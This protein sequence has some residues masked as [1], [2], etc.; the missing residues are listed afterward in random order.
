MPYTRIVNHNAAGI[1]Q[2]GAALDDKCSTNAMP[3][4]LGHPR[5]TII[6]LH[7]IDHA[8]ITAHQTFN[9]AGFLLSNL[10]HS[11][12]ADFIFRRWYAGFV[13]AEW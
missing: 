1:Q 12:H 7:T 6:K 4:C 13:P 8:T 10:P 9:L 11:H 3:P 5:D 2:R